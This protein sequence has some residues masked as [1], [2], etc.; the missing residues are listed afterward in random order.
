MDVILVGNVEEVKAAAE[1]NGFDISKAEIIDPATYE[2][3]TR[4]W[5]RWW[6]CARA[7]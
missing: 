3:W 1:K 4:W 2:A 7:R 6:S 5:R